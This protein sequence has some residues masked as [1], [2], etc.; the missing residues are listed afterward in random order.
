[1]LNDDLVQPARGFG[2]HPH[3]DVEICTYVVEGNLT[4]QD[5]MGTKETLTRGAVQFMTAGK[6][7]YHSEH[8]LDPEKPLRFL[9]LWITTRQRGLTPNYGSFP[10][11]YSA[12]LNKWSHLVSDVKSSV[13]VP[14]KINQDANIYVT[15]LDNSEVEVSFTLEQRRQ[16]YLVCIEGE[17]I[18][19]GN[20]GESTVMRHDAAEIFGPNTFTVRS[21]RSTS[22]AKES[23]E[24]RSTHATVAHLLLVEM[25]FEGSG[26]L[27]L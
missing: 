10:G 4:H 17:V 13:E 6:G 12:R 23:E 2:E 8:N 1:M 19:K 22:S 18:V 16:A 26:R 3:H 25:A 5:S 15:E 21:L 9:Q 11:D 14:I 20:H 7:V 24:S 27:D